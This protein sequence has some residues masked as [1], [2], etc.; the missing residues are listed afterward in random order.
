MESRPASF[1]LRNPYF[2]CENGKEFDWLKVVADSGL[3][4]FDEQRLEDPEARTFAEGEC[5]DLFGGATDAV[6][7][8]N[9]RSRGEVEGV[10]VGV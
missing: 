8:L 2:F 3:V 4:L 7:G 10:G 6:M 5:G 1:T 9:S